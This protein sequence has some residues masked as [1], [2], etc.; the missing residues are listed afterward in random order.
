MA[1]PHEGCVALY[2]YLFKVKVSLPLHPFIHLFLRS[3]NVA[4]ALLNLA[5]YK[6]ILGH[7]MLWNRSGVQFE[8]S[9]DKFRR[10]YQVKSTSRGNG[11]YNLV[12]WARID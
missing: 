5:I 11:W 3:L 12:S 7:Y 8:F 2:S 6:A 9:L 1:T 10:L 4:F